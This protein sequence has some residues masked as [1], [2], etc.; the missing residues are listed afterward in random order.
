MDKFRALVKLF[1]PPIVLRLSRLFLYKG[2]NSAQFFKDTS[3]FQPSYVDW[4]VTTVAGGR[5]IEL[6][7]LL[8]HTILTPE[9]RVLD[10][11]AT[12]VSGDWHRT[13][14]GQYILRPCKS[15]VA[16]DRRVPNSLG[17]VNHFCVADGTNIPFQDGS[18]DMVM[19]VSALEHAGLVQYGQPLHD[20]ADFK[21]F[22][23]MLRVLCVNGQLLLT[24]PFGAD[25]IHSGW[26]RSYTKDRLNQ[27]L[28]Y[29]ADQ[30]Y[31]AKEV[32]CKYFRNSPI[33]WL[34]SDEEQ[35]RLVRQYEN[36]KGDINGL[37]C[38][39]LIRDEH[40]VQGG[41]A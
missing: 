30:G 40:S 25:E 14:T 33:G 16:I 9:Q 19:C 31:P 38:G 10:V 26:I 1:V 8:R 2:D 12:I 35:L 21:V 41:G 37:Y 28:Q 29:A 4:Q 34:H 5:A 7:W 24:V 32:E 20:R 6:P 39:V 22:A 13:S 18:F 15:V 11:G 36:P 17:I 23:E 3:S 27:L